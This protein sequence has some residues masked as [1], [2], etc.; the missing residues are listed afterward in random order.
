MPMTTAFAQTVANAA[1]GN[2]SFTPAANTYAAL[3]S[4]TLTA[5]GSGTELTGNGYSRVEMAYSIANGIATSTANVSFTCSGN[6]WPTVRS[7]AI[8]DAS[9]GGNMLFYQPIAGRNV[10]VGDT[11]TFETGNIQIIIT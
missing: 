10:K 11:L 8:L 1:V 7:L 2:V 3:Y 5:A 6:N 9:S 4:T